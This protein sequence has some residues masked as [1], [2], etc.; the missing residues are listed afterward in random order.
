V[1]AGKERKR[2]MI[3]DSVLGAL[4]VCI[5]GA[6]ASCAGEE[7]PTQKETSS[8]NGTALPS[9]IVDQNALLAEVA[10]EVPGFAG[11]HLDPQATG[12]GDVYIV[13]STVRGINVEAVKA[14]IIKR[15]P[16]KAHQFADAEFRVEYVDYDAS[17]LKGWWD[18]VKQVVVG[19]M[20]GEFRPHLGMMDLDEAHNRILISFYSEE[21]RA[22]A[23]ERVR[24]SIDPPPGAIVV[25]LE[26]PG[27]DD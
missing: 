11:Y 26:E 20:P 25:I 23:E 13:N 15:D 10:R 4:L 17:Q 27:Q 9:G 5:A 8:Q 24:E 16:S 14:A 22:W 6:V 2:P 3:L 7:G 19:E 1:V 21:A 12:A 18:E